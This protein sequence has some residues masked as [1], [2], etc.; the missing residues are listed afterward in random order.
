LD[1]VT[2]GQWGVSRYPADESKDANAFLPYMLRKER[3]GYGLVLPPY[4]AFLG[5]VFLKPMKE[6]K[7]YE[8]INGLYEN[9]PE[10]AY[11]LHRWNPGQTNWL[12]AYWR[13]LSQE[14]H[15][16]YILTE[17]DDE[18]KIWK[19][20]SGRSRTSIRK[21][22]KIHQIEELSDDFL[23][24]KTVWMTKFQHNKAALT[25]LLQ[26]C[27]ERNCRKILGARDESGAITDLILLVWDKHRLYYLISLR[28][29]EKP[30]LGGN[31]LLLWEAIKSLPEGIE[32]FDF[33]GS[34][35]KG[36]ESFFRSFGG[37]SDQ[38]FQISGTFSRYR[39]F[40]KALASLK[41]ALKGS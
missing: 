15:Y 36:I 20:L 33:E 35:I 12:P 21:A 11:I 16:T 7:Q 1:A 13:G 32:V 18:E 40:R 5:P 23:V 17:L 37:R 3:D 8:A 28:D 30:N 24:E 6:G 26:A 41:Q 39:H 27:K 4:T 19:N 38:I 9:L 31:S 29:P 14:T 25:R 10:L 22:E 34:M 2:D